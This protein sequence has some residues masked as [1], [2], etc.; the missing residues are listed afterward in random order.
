TPTSGKC[1]AI[2]GA[3]LVLFR[4]SVSIETIASEDLLPK[5]FCPASCLLILRTRLV[6]SSERLMEA[7]VLSREEEIYWLALRLVPGLRSRTCGNLRDRFGTPQAI[8]RASRTELEGA[9]G[10]GRLAQSIARGCAFDEA[11]T[12]Q[13]RMAKSGAVAVPIIDS[14]YPRS[15]RDIFD[16][17]I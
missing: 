11:A 8:L 14:R 17:P 3:F 13:E 10:S 15:L 4:K 9:G 6:V 12:Q 2:S 1:P 7:P 5:S 16:P